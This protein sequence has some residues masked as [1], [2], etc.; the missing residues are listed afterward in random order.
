[1]TPVYHLYV[2]RLEENRRDELRAHLQSR[3]IEAEIHY[4]R[5]APLTPAFS[6]LGYRPQD[7][8]VAE[9]YARQILSLPMYPELN[10]SQIEY[11]VSEIEHFMYAGDIYETSNAG[12]RI[13]S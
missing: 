13:Q 11:V 1:M 4:P 9:A 2:I 7:F 6:Y 12:E 5:L 3:G 8:P 10:R